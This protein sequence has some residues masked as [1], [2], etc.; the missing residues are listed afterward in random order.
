[1]EVSVRTEKGNLVFD[2]QT[3]D[4]ARLVAS[5]RGFHL[6]IEPM[7]PGAA[8]LTATHHRTGAIIRANGTSVWH[9]AE[10]LINLLTES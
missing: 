3:L 1:M 9:A 5:T 7:G 4:V 2:A 8:K 6:D 10:K